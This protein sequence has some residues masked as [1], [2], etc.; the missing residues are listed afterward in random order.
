MRAVR[1]QEAGGLVV[2]DIAV[3]EPGPGQ[4][5]VRVAGAGLCH[6]D[7][8]I[9]RMPQAHGG[10]PFTIG[11]ETAGWVAA[12]GPGVRGVREGDAVLVHNL[13]GC[14]ECARC[15]TGAE[16]F[17][18]NTGGRLGAGLGH[19]G[20]AADLLL[21]PAARH[22]V[23]LGG[24]DPLDA[25]PLDDAALTPY[26]AIRTATGLGPGAVALVI[27]AGGLG[28]MAI[29]LLR[30]LTPATIVAVETD[31]ARRRFAE[32]LGADL[33]LDPADDAVAQI[34]ALGREGVTFALDLVGSDDTLA[35]AVA[36]SARGGDIVMAGAALGSTTFSL[37][38]VPF[39]CRLR[40]TYGGELSELEDIVA[41]AQAGRIRV[42]THYIS[43]DEVPAH[44]E[45][46]DTGHGPVGRIVAVPDHP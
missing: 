7:C 17:C 46:L 40:S 14:G 9:S 3:P 33:V 21:V 35:L 38:A 1:V 43:L 22:V 15:R 31:P 30:T 36:A 37:L 41:L 4:V 18:T 29:Q 39:E 28:H 2:E 6:S 20:G 42:Q 13:W 27:G 16:R 45:L 32:E 44:I 23:A 5:L 34:K 11:H 24:L 8:L 26:H 25:G 10:G 19:D 12:T